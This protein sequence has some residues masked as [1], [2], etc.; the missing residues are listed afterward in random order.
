[1]Q[2]RTTVITALS[3][4]TLA[5]ASGCAVSV[6]YTHLDVY[7]RQPQVFSNGSALLF[8]ARG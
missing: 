7:K 8:R 4:L 5:L 3:V 1:M 2:L 6:S